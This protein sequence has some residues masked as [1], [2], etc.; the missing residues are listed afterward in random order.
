LKCFPIVR[1]YRNYNQ[2]LHRPF[3]AKGVLQSLNVDE[4]RNSNLTAMYRLRLLL[5]M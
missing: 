1:S 2:L 4:I 5:V 3:A